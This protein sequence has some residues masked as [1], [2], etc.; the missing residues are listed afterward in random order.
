M[1]DINQIKLLRDQL[2]AALEIP[3]QNP[4]PVM[5]MNTQGTLLYTNPSGADL[6]DQMGL[7]IGSTMPSQL[8]EQATTAAVADLELAVGVHRFSFHT[9]AMPELAIINIY[10]KDVTAEQAIAR[11]PEENPNPVLRISPAGILLYANAGASFVL[12]SWNLRPGSTVPT[13]LL[14]HLDNSSEQ[15]NLELNCGNRTY[16]FHLVTVPKT[17]SINIYGTD[18]T[19]MRALTKFPDQNPNPVL[20]IDMNGALLYANPA[21]EALRKAWA[22]EL[23]DHVPNRFITSQQQPTGHSFEME[24]GAHYYLF[25]L[26]NVP[27]F[28]FINIYGTDITAAK[29]NENILMKLAKYFSPQ[30]YESIFTGDL[31]VKIQTKRKRLTVFFSDIKGFGQLT[32]R[33]EPEVLTEL[34]TE[35][36]TAMT[37]IAVKH[38]GTVDKYI[39]DAVMVFF[40]DP[41]SNGTKE[42]ALACIRMALEMKYSLR[43][44][45]KT[46][47]EKGISRPLDI[48]I[49]IHS[50]TCTV[51]NFG[52]SDRLDYTT[53]GNGVNLASR[54]ESSANANQI[55]ISEDTYLLVKDE[56]K[57]GKLDMIDVKNITH[58][59]QT[60]EVL[61]DRLGD[62]SI[63]QLDEA[64]DG[65][66]LYLDPLSIKDVEHKRQLLERALS[67]L[68]GLE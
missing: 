5:T 59:I 40:G 60:F 66:E 41:K 62:Q 18:V 32:E 37:A 15:H 28:D 33:L 35:Y 43:S 3:G 45:K 4:N 9:V 57:C 34:I 51:G 17:D 24:I 65:F 47:K 38:G 16:S 52:S 49:G 2:N 21:A 27:A 39:G 61:S 6:A 44:L 12:E 50:D 36:L 20:R 63:D 67:L 26:S 42:D 54:L 58:P 23:G 68:E 13:A 56:I 7:T 53:I 11:F 8:V 30:V 14:A 55:L 10:V 48:R 31:D 46:W 19:A 64:T 22:I 25:H 29:D 1:P